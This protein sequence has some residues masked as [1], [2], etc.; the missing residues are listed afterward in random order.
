MID[1][2]CFLGKYY[3][4]KKSQSTFYRNAHFYSV[5]QVFEWLKRSGFGDIKTCQTIFK[6]P[7]DMTAI[8][9]AKKG[10]GKGGF[11]VIAAQKEV[12]T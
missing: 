12:K 9:P 7:K 3:E 1:K 8:E 6:L 4:A 10:H 2:N 5:T 11:V